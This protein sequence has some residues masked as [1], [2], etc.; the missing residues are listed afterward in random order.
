[1]RRTLVKEILMLGRLGPYCLQLQPN[2]SGY[3]EKYRVLGA[4][5]LCKPPVSQQANFEV[6]SFLFGECSASVVEQQL[7]LNTTENGNGGGSHNR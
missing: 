5:V 3:H 1:M 2:R 4:A 6:G 7:P